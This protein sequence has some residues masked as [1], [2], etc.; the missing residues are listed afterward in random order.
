ML[1]ATDEENAIAGLTSIVTEE[2]DGGSA[3]YPSRTKRAQRKKAKLG[4]VKV[5]LRY[6]KPDGKPNKSKSVASSADADFEG[7]DGV[8]GNREI[9]APLWREPLPA[10]PVQALLDRWHRR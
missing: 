3:W 9:H 8:I 7:G 5:T 2:G 4:G 10:S 6:A 1:G